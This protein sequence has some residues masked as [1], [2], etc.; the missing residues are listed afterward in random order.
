MPS[1]TAVKADGPWELTFDGTVYQ[2]VEARDLWNRIM[3]ATYDYAEPGV[4]FIDRINAMNNLALLRDHLRHQPLRRAAAAALRRLPARL[5]QPRAAGERPVRAGGARSTRRSLRGWCATAVRMMDNV[6]DASRFPLRGAAPGG[7]GQAAHR[8]WR[9]RAGRC[10]AHG[11][12]ALRLRRGRRADRSLDAPDRPRRLSRLASSW[13]GRKAPFP[14]FDAEAFLAS[15]HACSTWTRTCATRSRDARHPQR[16]A[17][18]DRADR[19]DLASTP[20]T[21]PPASSRS[22]PMPTPA[23]CCR[24][25]AHAPR[26]RSSTTPS[27]LWREKFGDT[28]AAG[29][30]RQRP[31]AGA[32][33]P[34]EDAGGG[35][36][37]DRQLDLQDHQRARGHLLRGLQGRL[38]AGLR[39]R[40]Q[41]LH[42]LPAQRGDRGAC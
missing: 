8:A 33:R 4:I 42:H 9:H 6:I 13:P 30:F 21:S 15:R 16:A 3:R 14:L 1:W 25:T 29:P 5:D 2:T 19:H 37:M 11:R 20:A 32:A 24:R 22:S 40:L 23:R 10:A 7:E 31:D 38:R 34:C 41:G 26:K 28:A 35:A 17:H 27:R 12:P 36:E 39:D 18:L